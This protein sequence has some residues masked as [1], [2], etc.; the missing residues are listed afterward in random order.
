MTSRIVK[1]SKK[2][3]QIKMRKET[4]KQTLYKVVFSKTPAYFVFDHFWKRWHI[5][6]TFCSENDISTWNLQNIFLYN[7]AVQNLS[8]QTFLAFCSH[9]QQLHVLTLI[10]YKVYWHSAYILYITFNMWPNSPRPC[11]FWDREVNLELIVSGM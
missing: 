5:A 3:S 2:N 1:H 9:H 8:R 11:W 6:N 7:I 10:I 4:G